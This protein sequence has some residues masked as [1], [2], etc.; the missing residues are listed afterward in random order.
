ME[1]RFFLVQID[2]DHSQESLMGHGSFTSLEK[3]IML[4]GIEDGVKLLFLDLQIANQVL[5]LGLILLFLNCK[6]VFT[7]SQIKQKLNN[8]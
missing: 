4:L 1:P 5:L 6:K 8:I 3:S 7:L 2:H